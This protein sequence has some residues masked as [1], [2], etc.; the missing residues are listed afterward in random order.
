MRGP[1]WAEG[2]ESF[3][4]EV[5]F[6]LSLVTRLLCSAVPEGGKSVGFRVPNTWFYSISITDTCVILNFLNCNFLIC[7]PKII[8]AVG[9]G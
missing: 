8:Y 2:S 6:E 3:H 1:V 5:V 4:E 9:F 7:T